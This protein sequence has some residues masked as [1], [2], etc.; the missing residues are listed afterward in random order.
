MIL[1]SIF[2]YVSGI[3]LNDYFDLEIDRK[4]R[5]NR[6]LA[7]GRIAKRNVMLL[8]VVSII[9][10]NAFAMTASWASLLISAILTSVII[11]YD[12]R[13]KRSTVA[14]P[15]P[16]GLARFLNIVLGGSPALGWQWV[17]SQSYMLLV[18][19][20]Y[21]LFIYT[22]AISILTRKEISSNELILWIKKDYDFPFIIYYASVVIGSI[23]VVGL[24][25][26]QSWFVFNLVIFSC[27]MV[28]AF[29]HL[30]MK[31]R[32]LSKKT[33]EIKQEKIQYKPG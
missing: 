2:L 19:I 24:D 21:C 9:A 23:L 28:F 33:R 18:F 1:S 8:A 13:L 17:P 31:L 32:D 26:F 20:G 4:E 12:F 11:A 22:T 16:M 3:A 30:I 27:V 15:I 10:G 5:P 25:N 14:N 6:P 7:S 29:L